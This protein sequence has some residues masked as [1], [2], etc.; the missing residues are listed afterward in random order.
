MR[1][2]RRILGTNL[3]AGFL[4]AALSGLLASSV[5]AETFESFLEDYARALVAEDSLA[6]RAAWWP[7][8][9]AHSER[10]GLLYRPSHPK[11]DGSS[12]VLTATELLRGDPAA[13][14]VESMPALLGFSRI[15][16][17][18]RGGTQ[19]DQT[20]YYARFDGDRWWLHHPLRPLTESWPRE[21]SRYL[22]IRR[23]PSRPPN[24]PI[25][26]ALDRFIDGSARRLGISTDRLERLATAGIDWIVAPE[27]IVTELVGTPTE[28]VANLQVDTVVTQ[29]DYHPHELAHILIRLALGEAPEATLPMYQE[30][31][32]VWLGGRFNAAAEM[33][34]E[35]GALLLEN[36]FVDLRDLLRSS[37]F[38]ELPGDLS[39]APSA[40]VVELLHNQ[41]GRSRFLHMYRE[42][43]GT[44]GETNSWPTPRLLAAIADALGTDSAGVQPA[45]ERYL[46]SRRPARFRSGIDELPESA[47][48]RSDAGILASWKTSG[49]EVHLQLRADGE[50]EL[51]GGF[52]WPRAGVSSPA[53]EYFEEHFPGR[54]FRGE[55]FA[56]VFAPGEL[57]LYDYQLGIL[58]AK[59]ADGFAPDPRFWDASAQ[60]M[61]VRIDRK[62][63]PH[64][65]DDAEF[66]AVPR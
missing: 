46:A 30:G 32:A 42:H 17:R 57:G 47:R 35:F 56:L 19:Q 34:L 58:V 39:Y 5:R 8:D 25:L 48:T 13:L 41:L 43:T 10:L 53:G 60:E 63:L 38:R 36:D 18:L 27:E 65:L 37:S 15:R 24:P 22:R 55:R 49:R 62:L 66:V 3:L 64:P 59:R 23:H 9:L 31:V 33:Q 14:D 61:R 51:R 7:Q 50:A 29:H 54:E 11:I 4:A 1:R 6:A 16:L 2:G 45:L 26:R 28:A 21:R 12:V 52:L 40:V 20:I 44:L